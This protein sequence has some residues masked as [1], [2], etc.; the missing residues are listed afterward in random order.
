MLHWIVFI[1][2][3]CISRSKQ[4]SQGDACIFEKIKQSRNVC[5]IYQIKIFS[6]IFDMAKT[7]GTSF[8]KMT[9]KFLFFLDEIKFSDRLLHSIFIGLPSLDNILS[10]KH[11]HLGMM[12]TVS[13]YELAKTY[14]VSLQEFSMRFIQHPIGLEHNPRTYGR[15]VADPNHK[16]PEP[17]LPRHLQCHVICCNRNG[18]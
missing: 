18:R 11:S 16:A 10:R 4:Q 14:Q 17:C 12:V 9:V 13:K 1:L 7:C 6:V 2:F 5:S 15:F 8:S 3:F